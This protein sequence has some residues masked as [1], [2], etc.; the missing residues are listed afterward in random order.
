[1]TANLNLT[2]NTGSAIRF[3]A[4]LQ[5]GFPAALKRAVNDTLRAVKAEHDRAIATEFQR[6]TPYMRNSLIAF[7]SSL[8]RPQDPPT[9]VL[10]WRDGFRTARGSG[11]TNYAEAV[12]AAFSSLRDTPAVKFVAPHVAGGERNTKR[13]EAKLQAAG[14][15]PAGW[16]VVPG[17]D[18]RL[19][20][21]GNISIG[22]IRQVLSQ[23]R[24]ASTTAGS[25]QNL[26]PR[27]N[28]RISPRKRAAAFKRAGGQYFALPKGRGRLPPGIY[29]RNSLERGPVARSISAVMLF[30]PATTYRRIYAFEAIS[31]RTADA[32]FPAAFA[33]RMADAQRAAGG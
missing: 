21:Y 29:R 3:T 6:P 10:R 25:Q 13:F 26:T 22:Q 16:R 8:A 14:Y 11:A 4:R 33:R 20:A 12:G 17:K 30:V 23:L 9:A 28:D 18:A 1:M 7:Y 32:V 31:Q 15:M 19:D 2:H 5:Q 27:G 24:I